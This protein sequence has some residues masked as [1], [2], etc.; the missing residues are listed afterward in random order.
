MTPTTEL[1]AINIMLETIGA[2]PVV[3]LTGVRN[4][5]TI[6][7]QSILDQVVKELQ[8]E[9]WHFNTEAGYPFTP[10]TNGHITVPANITRIEPDRHWQGP[11]DVTIRGNLL[12]DR[13]NHTTVFD[14]PFTAT[15]VL[16]LAFDELPMEAKTYVTI[17]AAR[18][19]Q[20]ITNGDS[21]LQTWTA[22]DEARL[23]AAF[24]GADT[25]QANLYMGCRFKLDPSIGV[26]L[27]R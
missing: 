5:D 15:V 12:Y 22:Q 17:R 25:R 3:T 4:Q 20:A 16:S 21:N 7:A 14:Q 26:D 10:D 9:E 6:V 8:V 2:A 19:F 24:V 18:K 13:V 23:R 1:S 27:A 11:R